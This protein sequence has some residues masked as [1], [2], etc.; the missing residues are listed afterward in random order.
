[1][2]RHGFSQCVP[3]NNDPS[4][5][6]QPWVDFSSGYVQRSLDK[7]PKQGSKKPWRLH[8]NYALDLIS[9]RFGSVVDGAMHYSPRP[10][11]KEPVTA[12]G[13]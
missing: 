11:Q 1:M 7:F 13:S 12:D 5:A 3:L 10:V 6:E 8:Q 4:V 9:L 2:D